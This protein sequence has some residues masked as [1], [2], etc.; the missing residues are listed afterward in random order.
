MTKS[1]TIVL[2]IAGRSS[3]FPGLRPKWMLSAPTGELML[4]K[5]LSSVPDWRERRIVVGALREHLVDQKGETALRRAFGDAIEIVSF[6]DQTSGPAET[7]E[8][9]L[10]RANVTEP[11]F[12]KDCDSWFVSSE[13]VFGDCVCYVDLAQ[14]RDVSN[15]AAKS[16]VHLNEHNIVTTIVEKIV[17]STYI[18]VGG[19]G[20][21]DA[22]TYLAAYEALIG[23]GHPGEPFISHVILEAMHQGSVF[24]GIGVDSYVDVGTLPAWNRFRAKQAAYFV[25]VDG[26]V[27]KN[28]G[29]YLPPFW[30]G[31]DEALPNNVA[32][33]K[34]LAAGG[35]QLIFVTARPESYRQKTESKLAEL[36]LTWHAFIF[37]INHASRTLINDYAPSNPYPSAS[38]LNLIRNDDALN[39]L[40]SSL[41]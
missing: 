27:L 17:S 8:K 23:S 31:P 12:V 25:D 24:K 11:F 7:V 35:A 5:S 40:I 10:T 37:G 29:Q 28:A 6:D 36:G 22:Q 18:S 32:A 16:F 21:R 13:S 2:P 14:S 26:V 41:D 34:K 3:R 1:G 4:E 19:Y 38:A 39:K 15:V 33:L 20:F 9:I 30:D